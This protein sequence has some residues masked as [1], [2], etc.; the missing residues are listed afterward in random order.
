MLKQ[1]RAAASEEHLQ[2]HVGVDPATLLVMTDLGKPDIATGDSVDHR[3]LDVLIGVIPHLCGQINATL[4]P[5]Q[6]MTW[7]VDELH[8]VVMVERKM[9]H[10]SAVLVHPASTKCAVQS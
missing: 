2:A 9:Q 7:L 10:H 1:A 6:L 8:D 3:V 5:G 4:G